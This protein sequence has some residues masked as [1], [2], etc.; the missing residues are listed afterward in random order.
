MDSQSLI[1]L[2]RKELSEIKQKKKYY[3]K[4][5]NKYQLLDELKKL[6]KKNT[7]LKEKIENHKLNL[8]VLQQENDQLSKQSHQN[9]YEI[10]EFFWNKKQF[11][12]DYREETLQK[13]A[14]LQSKTQ[15]LKVEIDQNKQE[16]EELELQKNKLKQALKAQSS[17][18]FS[19]YLTYSSVVLLVVCTL[20]Y[21]EIQS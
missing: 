15:K 6:D 14:L 2:L 4:S 7:E 8:P 5:P 1:E 19:T 16:I 10:E 18:A 13:E 17:N 20:L 12:F 21:L 9:I 3:E 11:L